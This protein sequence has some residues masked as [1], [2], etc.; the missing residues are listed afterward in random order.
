MFQ[1]DERIQPRFTLTQTNTIVCTVAGA[2]APVDSHVSRT[3]AG[4][5]L[6]HALT[7]RESTVL[8]ARELQTMRQTEV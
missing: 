3:G 2:G 6:H 8:L 1:F 5:A 4:S 7:S